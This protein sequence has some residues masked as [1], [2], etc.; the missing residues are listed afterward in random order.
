MPGSLVQK[1]GKVVKQPGNPLY[2]QVK[3]AIEN[4]IQDGNFTSGDI[5][6]TERELSRMYNVSRI[7]VRQ[8]L[9]AL[10]REDRVVHL[11]QK[12]VMVKM[13]GSPTRQS[14][15]GIG[16]IGY[17]CTGVSP[18]F[19]D[20]YFM[21]IMEGIYEVTV[22]NKLGAPGLYGA[23]VTENL[24]D[25]VERL[26]RD[27]IS[28]VVLAS[29][30]PYSHL[31][32]ICESVKHVVLAD[33]DWDV[34]TCPRVYAPK[35]QGTY[36]LVRHLI[37]LGH[38]RIGFIGHVSDYEYAAPDERAHLKFDGFRNF[39]DG[40]RKALSE[41][42]IAEE[43]HLIEHVV[44]TYSQ[45]EAVHWAIRR[46]MHLDKRPTAVFCHTDFAASHVLDALREFGCRVPEDVAVVS[47]DYMGL[48]SFVT[49]KLT[50]M[51]VPRRQIGKIAAAIL[52]RWL[53]NKTLDEKEVV[54]PLNLVIRDSCGA[55][56]KFR[57]TS[58][59]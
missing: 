35:A 23:D 50:S 24:P 13:A 29:S 38:R 42:G 22:Q 10:A 44:S 27:E 59:E 51:S 15:A 46:L 54:V 43:K 52:L 32:A 49:P 57:K 17:V 6:P 11:P 12:G 14:D 19:S 55:E 7:T 16:R 41:A 31:M 53:R 34:E 45:Q 8:A 47:F 5:L 36:E 25:L 56:K 3:Q 33:S 9:A 26:R 30:I 58:A 2:L 18:K 39:I 21:G 28:G 20:P 48:G 37:G 1:S 4:K 40:Y